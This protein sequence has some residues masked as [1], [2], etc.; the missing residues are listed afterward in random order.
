MYLINLG[1]RTYYSIRVLLGMTTP[2]EQVKDLLSRLHPVMAN[3]P[4]MEDTFSLTTLTVL[5]HAFHQASGILHCLKG[6]APNWA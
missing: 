3:K 4:M 5:V 1:L 6:S 2:K